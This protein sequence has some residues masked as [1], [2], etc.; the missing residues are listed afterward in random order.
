MNMAAISAVRWFL[1]VAWKEKLFFFVNFE[2]RYN[3]QFVTT[4]I[5]IP[6]AD[7]LKGIYTY[8]VSGTTNQLRTANVLD[9]AAAKG[10]PTKLDSVSQSILNTNTQV[11]TY[12]RPIADNDFNRDTYTFDAENNLNQYFPTTRVDYFITPKQQVTFTWNYYHSWQPGARRLPVPDIQRTNP[13]RIGYFVYSGALQSTLSP[14]TLNEFRYGVQHSGD[15]NARDEYGPYYTF[16]G[17]PLRIGP[18]LQFS[19]AAPNPLG[20]L[21]PFID[22]PNTTG[23]HFI[24]TV[25]DTLTLNRGQHTITV[26]G[27][28]RKTDWK[29]IGQVFPVPTYATGT[30]SGD[31]LQASSAFTAATLPGINS[32]L[33]GRPAGALQPVD[34]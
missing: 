10:L 27:S 7:A 17:K 4:T 8:V 6:T 28:Y 15:T 16:D 11:P 34:R 23:R 31:P 20:P 5:A 18:T 21:V 14:Q 26:G 32:T 25:Y 9:L 30:P 22:Q 29:D 3:P 24:T 33:S 2:K 13:F 1:L 19:L 12:A